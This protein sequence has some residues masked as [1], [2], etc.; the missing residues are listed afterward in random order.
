MRRNKRRDGFAVRLE[1]FILQNF[2]PFWRLVERSAFLSRLVN[3]FVINA[4]C[5]T[6]P[7]RPHPMS[8]L[9][10]Y[11]SWSSLTDLTYFSRQLPPVEAPPSLPSV[12]EATSLFI[13]AGP[14]PQAECPKSTLLFPVFAQYLTDGFLRTNLNDRRRTTS[15]HQIDLSQLYGRTPQQVAAL[16]LGSNQPGQKGRMKSQIINGEEFPPDLYKPGTSEVVAGFE[17]LDLPLDID[18]KWI[19]GEHYRRRIFAVGGDRAN[20]TPMIAMLNALFLREHN[21]LAAELEQQHPEWDDTRVFETARNILIVMFIKLV[22]EEYINHISFAC[23]GLRADPSVGW[24]AKWNKPNWMTVEFALLYRWHSLIPA[25]IIWNGKKVPARSMLLD[26]TPIIEAGLAQGF[27]SASQTNAA[28]LGLH[29][30]AVFL[31]E[32]LTVESKAI[33]QNRNLHLPG[34][35]AYRKYMGMPDVDNFSYVTGDPKRRAE[36]ENLYGSPENMDF[37]VGLFAEDAGENT[38]LPLLM[39]NM[40]GLDAFSQALTNPLL[41]KQVFNAQTFTQ[42]GMDTIAA[43]NAIGDILERNLQGKTVPDLD[44]K[45]VRMTRPDWKRRFA[46]F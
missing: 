38:P 11:T 43:T 44:T 42:F 14:G 33:E 3:G 39:G 10:D 35:N 46:P 17:V 20:V 27:L 2:A 41:S 18:L 5:A 21:R 9:A 28:R 31:E 13:H 12:R 4:T 16:R 36:L 1:M 15:N 29:N 6:A 30:T 19:E 7:F 22:I 34:Y 32:L 45:A 23:I 25:E 40:V 37:Y 24:E 8:T 26:N